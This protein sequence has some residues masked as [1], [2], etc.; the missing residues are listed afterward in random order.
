MDYQIA[1]K[2]EFLDKR[3]L[4]LQAL[5]SNAPF[6]NFNFPRIM[7]VQST[8]FMGLKNIGK[9]LGLTVA[10]AT[11]PQVFDKVRNVE[12]DMASAALAAVRESIKKPYEAGK[13]VE[14]LTSAGFEEEE[15]K[16]IV[17]RAYMDADRN[18]DAIKM[19]EELGSCIGK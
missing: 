14:R 12:N 5:L 16:R 2:N 18:H 7:R 11:A 13:A 1:A 9:A 8:L 19:Y 15:A 3:K 10:V 4:V 17:A 6:D